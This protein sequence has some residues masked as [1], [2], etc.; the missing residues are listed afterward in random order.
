M[1]VDL[2]IDISTNNIFKDNY[3]GVIYERKILYTFKII[4]E[5]SNYRDQIM[6]K[7]HIYL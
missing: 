5:P 7:N 3:I 2:N 6:N 4:V 1:H